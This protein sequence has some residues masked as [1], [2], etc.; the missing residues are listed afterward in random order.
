MARD[1]A[2]RRAEELL[3][4][5]KKGIGELVAKVPVEAYLSKYVELRDS[6][7]SRKKK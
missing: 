3:A 2:R 7:K 5:A 4:L 6:A 1:L